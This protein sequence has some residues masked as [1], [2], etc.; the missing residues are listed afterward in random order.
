MIKPVSFPD[1]RN[2]F[3]LKNITRY[4]YIKN[5]ITRRRI[6]ETVAIPSLTVSLLKY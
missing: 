5:I 1:V 4:L 3:F 6:N 2:N